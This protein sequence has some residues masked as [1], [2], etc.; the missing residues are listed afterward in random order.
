MADDDNGPLPTLPQIRKS[1]EHFADQVG[2]LWG[3]TGH[4]NFP[5]TPENLSDRLLDVAHALMEVTYT[6]HG[7]IGHLERLEARAAGEAE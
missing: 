2:E 1:L 7:C 5:D 4:P 3:K 6:I